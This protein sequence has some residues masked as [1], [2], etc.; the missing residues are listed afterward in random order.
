M[1]EEWK[2][3][4]GYEGLYQVSNLGRVKNRYNKILK[5][6][7][8]HGYLRLGLCKDN[9]IKNTSMHR[10]VAEHFIENPTYK[11]YVN[12]IDGVIHNNK[13]D[14]LEWCTQKEN[15]YHA[16]KN[17]LKIDRGENSSRHKLT[18]EN[19]NFIRLNYIPRDKV[20][21]AKSLSKMFGVSVR[22]IYRVIAKDVFN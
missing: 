17:G 7:T 6:S 21:N 5:G 11:P 19:V 20:F 8:S 12:H 13:V 14:N 3:V 2:Y 9:K 18:Q 22:E 16:I 15:V 1:V 10:L 4:K